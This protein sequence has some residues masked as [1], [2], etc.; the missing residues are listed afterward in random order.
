MIRRRQSRLERPT[1][2]D[3]R[4]GVA[5]SA[6]QNEGGNNNCFT[7]NEPNFSGGPSG[8]ACDSYHRYPEDHSLIREINC[9]THRL[10]IEW[11]RI[12]PQRG[13]FSAAELDHYDQVIEDM[14][15]KGIEPIITL[16]HFTNPIW[17]ENSGGW[18]NPSNVPAFQAFVDVI[19]KR[20]GQRVR[21]WITLNEPNV[22]VQS[23]YVAGIWHPYKK[24]F[25]DPYRHV[26]PNL[27]AAHKSAYGAIK[28][29]N[30]EAKVS[31]ASN[32]A[33]ILP[34]LN[35]YYPVNYIYYAIYSRF[36]NDYM[37]KHLRGA[38]DFLGLNFYTRAEVS[39]NLFGKL[40]HGDPHYYSIKPKPPESPQDFRFD[41]DPQDLYDVIKRLRKA[42]QLPVMVTENGFVTNDDE[43][44]VK[45]LAGVKE[46]LGR[47]RGEDAGFWGYMLWTLIDNWEWPPHG[48]AARFGIFDRDRQPKASAGTYADLAAEQ[49][50]LNSR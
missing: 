23:K 4:I 44:R 26:Y 34:K 15:A 1:F 42:Y 12:E 37:F 43:K 50:R 30:P 32:Y 27:I 49:V 47:L 16:H 8:E 40:R 11:S 19:V 14:L 9:N 21:Y 7:Q 36:S 45:Y 39:L 24:S 17:F 38:L 28:T 25:R 2:R 22:M 18:E 5:T 48:F 13:E 35:A 41:A 10:S 6:H 46:V 31:I 29:H 20:F 33:L 3:F